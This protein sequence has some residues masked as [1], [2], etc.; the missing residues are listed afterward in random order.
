MHLLYRDQIKDRRV[1]RVAKSDTCGKVPPNCARL[2]CGCTIFFV[3]HQNHASSIVCSGCSFCPAGFKVG[4]PTGAIAIPPE[5]AGDAGG[6]TEVRFTDRNKTP[7]LSPFFGCQ[8]GWSLHE[9]FYLP[10]TRIHTHDPPPAKLRFRVLCWNLLEPAVKLQKTCA[11]MNCAWS[12]NCV[13][14][15]VA[16]PCPLRNRP[17]SSPRTSPF[18]PRPKCR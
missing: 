12:L 5:L 4:N 11:R 15:V 13:K 14:R 10:L 9:S 18:R 16:P 7:P 6:L 1:W 17:S 3:T 2:P 8:S